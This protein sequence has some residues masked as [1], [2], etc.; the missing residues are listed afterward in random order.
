MD[1][2]IQIFRRSLTGQCAIPL[3]LLAI[4]ATILMQTWLGGEHSWSRFSVV[5]ILVGLAMTTWSIRHYSCIAISADG[6]MVRRIGYTLFSSWENVLEIEYRV[7]AAIELK[8]TTLDSQDPDSLKRRLIAWRYKRSYPGC[9]AILANGTLIP[10]DAFMSHIK[11]GELHSAIRHH[12]PRL[13]YSTGKAPQ[14]SQ[15]VSFTAS[16]EIA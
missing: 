6:V 9:Q 16:E 3:S 5:L 14:V 13:S 11:S 10:L 7:P 15:Q 8:T 2:K 4:A 1:S 12:W